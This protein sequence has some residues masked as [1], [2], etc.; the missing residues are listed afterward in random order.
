MKQEASVLK[1]AS[2]ML[3]QE[4]KNLDSIQSV[5]FVKRLLYQIDP[6][7]FY[8][9][10]SG[11]GSE[12]YAQVLSEIEKYFKNELQ[13]DIKQHIDRL[14]VYKNP[15]EVWELLLGIAIKGNNRGENITLILDMD[16]NVQAELVGIVSNIIDKFGQNAAPSNIQ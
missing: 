4:V 3:E 7:Q 2:L 5:T 15:M 8:Q 16:H 14:N 10:E 6:D 13:T 11:K 1:W 9:W 12:N